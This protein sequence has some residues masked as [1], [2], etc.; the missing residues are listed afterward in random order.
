MYVAFFV[1]FFQTGHVFSGGDSARC[2]ARHE[3][4]LGVTV[5]ARASARHYCHHSTSLVQC[6]RVSYSGLVEAIPTT[7]LAVQDKRIAPGPQPNSLISRP[8]ILSLILL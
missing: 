2:T 3:Q 5:I 4:A 7:F 1:V 6:I 8:G